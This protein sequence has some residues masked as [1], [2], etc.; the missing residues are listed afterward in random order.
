MVSDGGSGYQATPTFLANGP[1]GSGSGAGLDDTLA[2][3]TTADTVGL[4]YNRLVGILEASGGHDR[5]KGTALE[6]VSPTVSD[7]QIAS[8]VAG[9]VSAGIGGVLVNAD[10]VG[11]T[12]M[13]TF[14]TPSRI[15]AN[16]TITETT[17]FNGTLAMRFIPAPPE[18]VSLFSVVSVTITPT[19]GAEPVLGTPT[20]SLDKLDVHVRRNAVGKDAGTYTVSMN[21]LNHRRG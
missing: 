14:H 21:C 20:L 4:L 3:H 9:L 5:F 16:N 6:T 10:R 15:Y 12:R 11:K 8:I 19:A 17:Q 7:P 1:S 18:G 2:G 13:W